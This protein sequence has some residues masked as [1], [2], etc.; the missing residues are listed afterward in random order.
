M[1]GALRKIAVCVDDFGL[2]AG[3]NDATLALAESGRITATSCMVG[4]PAW[5]AGAKALARLPAEKIDLG[6]HLDLTAHPVAAA[7]RRPLPVLMGLA[8]GHLLDRRALRIEI[9]AQLDAFEQALGRQPDHIDGHQHVHQFPVVRELLLEALLAR[10]PRQRPWL[11]RTARAAGPRSG[12][13]KGWVIERFGCAGLGAQAR[14][15]GFKQN[16]HL[17]GVYDFEGDGTHYL[18]LLAQWTGA[19]RQG[20]LLMCHAAVAADA[21]DPIGLA[22]RNEYEV[23]SSAAFAALLAHARI[24][25]APLSRILATEPAYAASL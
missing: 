5:R 8:A 4:A 14:A 16:G 2:H 23:L 13:V 24:E 25:L 1:E 7:S 22:R 17:L 10:Y 3:I 11:R 19:A 9:A 21:N 6:L 18:D 20:D 12:G 15:H